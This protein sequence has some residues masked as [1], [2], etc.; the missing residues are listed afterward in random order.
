MQLSQNIHHSPVWLWHVAW[1]S[2]YICKVDYGE[3]QMGK[4]VNLGLSVLWIVIKRSWIYEQK[5]LQNKQKKKRNYT[6]IID[7]KS[8]CKIIFLTLRNDEGWSHHNCFDITKTQS[9]VKHRHWITCQGQLVQRSRALGDFVKTRSN[10]WKIF[11]YI[12]VHSHASDGIYFDPLQSATWI[13][14]NWSSL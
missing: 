4:I 10:V 7:S 14:R 1:W 6:K 8:K 9:G 5:K 11:S 12:Y 2:S 13:M 3:W